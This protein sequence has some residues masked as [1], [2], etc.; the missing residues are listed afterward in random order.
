MNGTLRQN[1]YKSIR[2]TN[3]IRT[4]KFFTNKYNTNPIGGEN[5]F[6]KYKLNTHTLSEV[7][8][9]HFS[10]LATQFK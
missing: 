4:C 6:T 5:K 8:Q 3:F 2:N 7:N 9:R 1:L 10:L